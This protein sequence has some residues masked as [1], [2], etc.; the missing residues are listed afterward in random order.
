MPEMDK[1]KKQHA[2]ALIK[3][4]VFG[5]DDPEK[6]ITTFSKFCL[7]SITGVGNVNHRGNN[8]FQVD[9]KLI[10]LDPT[11]S[12][13]PS[14]NIKSSIPNRFFEIQMHYDPNF[15]L[16]AQPAFPPKPKLSTVLANESEIEEVLKNYIAHPAVHLHLPEV[17]DEFINGRDPYHEIRIVAGSEN[18]FYL[19]YQIFFQII[20]IE[21]RY[22]NSERKQT[23]LR[24]LAAIIWK[25]K[26]KVNIG[27]G[28]L[29]PTKKQK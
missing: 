14:I 4:M 17:I 18:F 28:D 2:W 20:D 11:F 6:W 10:N 23:E 16:E 12:D 15:A 1:K 3:K 8:S 13:K 25:N 5:P 19:I 9:L 26:A 22:D 24:R 7:F 29:F 21:N 27:P